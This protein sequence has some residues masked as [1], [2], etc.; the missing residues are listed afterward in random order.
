M[1]EEGQ[2]ESNRAAHEASGV[3]TVHVSSET[4]G[5]ADAP[6]CVLQDDRYVVVAEVGRGGVGRVSEVRDNRLRRSVAMKKLDPALGE[7]PGVVNRFV[8]EAQIQ[9]QLDHPNVVPI[10]DVGVDASGAVY[11]T[12]K[13]VHGKSLFDWLCD[14]SR[15]PGSPERLSE[16]IDIFLKVCDAVA[17]AHSRG[18]LHRDLKPE[19]IMLGEFGE[20]YVMDW[21]LAQRTREDKPVAGDGHTKAS[22]SGEMIAG[23]P[24]YISPEAA[25][26]EPATERTDVFGLGVILYAIV[27][28]RS[29]YGA[30]GSYIN[31]L[32]AA[33]DGAIVPPERALGG[34][35]VSKKLLNILSRSLAVSPDSRHASAAAL[36]ADVQQFLRGGL[37]MPR[38]AYAAGTRIVVEGEPGDNAYIIVKGCCE[39]YKTIDGQRRTLRR[40]GPGEV[41]GETAVLSDLP[42]TATV[43]AIDTVTV[44]VIERA[45]LDEGLGFDTWLGTLVKA[46]ARRF[47]ELDARVSIGG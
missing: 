16:G 37:H 33:R 36:R 4:V 39:A 23:T 38:R 44:L 35:G 26:G 17:F 8:E 29:V 11:F 2:R 9:A 12:M 14:P 18:V 27:T 28:G 30:T 34:V 5:G 25:R 7:A 20:V 15:P 32:L 43:E 41:F 10:H 31:A 22:P 47:R 46:L 13:L 6:A 45:T 19:N 24:A 1:S 42:R 3:R 40:M 21:G